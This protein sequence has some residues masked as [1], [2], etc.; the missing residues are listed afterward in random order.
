MASTEIYI[1]LTSE[2]FS[3]SQEEDAENELFHAAGKQSNGCIRD[4]K[5][6]L[7][8]SDPTA[9]ESPIIYHYLTFET[10]LPSPSTL[11]SSDPNAPP[12]P[13]PPDLRDHVSPFTWSESRKNFTTWLSCAVTVVTAYT[14]GSYSPASVQLSA[15]WGVS[16]VA[17]YV[18]ITAFTTGFA[19][20]PMVLAPFSE[21]NGRKPVFVATGILFVICQLCCALTR[22]YPGMLLARFFAGVGGSTFST[23]V[24]GVVSDIYRA[25]D[26]NTA[27]ALF[28]GAALFGTGL[29]PLVSGFI[30]QRTT[31][32][33]IFYVQ[34]IDCGLLILAVALFMKETRGS[35][36]LSRKAQ[37]LNKWYEAR[38]K[39]GCI[40]FEVPVG[41][42]GCKNESQRI[43]WKVKADEERESLVKM[44]GISL[45]RP[46]HLLLTE[47]V[48]FFFSLWIA[49]SWAVLY[50]TFS[51]IPLVFSTNHHFNIEENGAVFAA[52]SV[53]AVISTILSIYQ[54]K[55][56]KHYGKL[57]STPEGRLYFACIESALMPIGLFWFGWTSFTS[58]HW[59]VPTLAIGCATMGIF[60]VYLAV[61][62]YLADTYGR[63]AS[64]AL[65]AQS[66][67]R[68]MLGGVFPLV[69]DQMFRAMTYPGA[70]SFLGGVGALLTIVPWV[71]VFYGPRIRAR[72]KFSSGMA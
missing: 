53:G 1:P 35:V 56:A 22:S 2:T 18:G 17:I 27:M 68:N 71:L 61:F 41:S 9:E 24:G 15:E 33:W 54:E 66:F 20:A 3:H 60:S 52:M 11:S 21:I 37:I 32:R 46:F 62:N 48:V 16:Q 29:G 51:A 49:F 12:A 31:W 67:C 7:S 23:M 39:A 26:R 42:N 44:I 57:S 14:A 4:E 70:S 43:R 13:E 50:L 64:S 47:P 5:N 45:Y 19:I 8:T 28:S 55:I 59:I 40:G 72:S 63:Y 30:A 65:A 58:I 38:E 6:S 36:L 69:T 34:T 25:E 10:E